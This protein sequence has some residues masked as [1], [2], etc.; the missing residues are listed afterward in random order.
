MESMDIKRTLFSVSDFLDWQRQGALDL[1]PPFQR[2]SVWKKGA[3]SYLIDTVVRGLPTPLIFI[4]EKIDPETLRPMR[5]VI[6]GQQ[7]L[8]T[9]L[10][11]IDE[12][13]LEDFDPGRDR[14]TVQ[15]VHNASVA[16][17]SFRKLDRGTRTR[18]L[19]YEFSTHV[20]PSDTEDRDILMIFA[21]LNSTGTPLN[22]QEL[23][24]AKYFG[25]L[26]TLMYQLAYEQLERW[27]EWRV[28]NEDQV[29]RMTEVELTSD[30]SL[31]MLDG[32]TGKS[33]P[34]LN[35]FYE[36]FDS[37]LPRKDELARRFRNVMDS[38]DEVFGKQL[39]A[40]V[41]TSEVY[42]FTLFTYLYDKMYGLGSDMAR[43][44]AK[45]LPRNL[46]ENLRKAS[47]NFRSQNVPPEV[48]D[49]VQRASADLGRRK[50][51]LSYMKTVCDGELT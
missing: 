15:K 24:N 1:D 16:D 8:R 36:K 30:L 49:A 21:R 39:P 42:F 31:N 3:K 35:K 43:R 18:I 14:F 22:P 46:P 19:G 50:T 34:K 2:R 11:F 6:D 38:I 23:R 7:R 51:R 13:S 20:L 9:L 32:L 44:P 45:R 17:R 37:Q 41:F 12:S 5:E 25:E 40:S 27:L 47:K 29:S 10:G 28:F 48:L 26:K 33:Q 4:R